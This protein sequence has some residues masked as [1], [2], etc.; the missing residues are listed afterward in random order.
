M[1]SVMPPTFDEWAPPQA[2]CQQGRT[3][4]IDVNSIRV[5]YEL[6]GPDGAPW[7][8]CLHSLATDLGVWE[9]QAGALSAGHRVLR[10]DM[11]GHGGSESSP[12][13][14]TL[15]LLVSD[16]VAVLDGLGI[17]RC[18]VMGLSIGAMLALG[19]AIDHPHRVD[20]VIVANARADAPAPYAAIWDAA[21]A[22]IHEGGL[23]LV[24]EA[25]VERWFSTAFRKNQPGTVARWRAR[26]LQTS[27]DG[28]VGCAR[29]VQGVTYL[30]R[31]DRIT[32]PT[33]FITGE[34]DLAAPPAAMSDMASRVAGA[35]FHIIPGAAHLTSIEAPDEF[36]A[37][38]AAFLADD[39]GTAAK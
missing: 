7:L 32:A 26:A 8:V 15:D 13:P 4:H 12:A 14:Y 36:L 21:I 37:L 38:A 33:V 17:D 5:H 1:T 24:I 27:V 29:A 11:R 30:S 39:H 25:A 3:M 23:Q 6:S 19:L 35:Q 18:D 28:F 34:N 10:L 22:S 20:R 31:L 16:V 2:H 9:G